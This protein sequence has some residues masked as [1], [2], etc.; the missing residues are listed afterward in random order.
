M[1]PKRS[2]IIDPDTNKLVRIGICLNCRKT[3]L[4]MRS[5]H[6][7]KKFCSEQCRRQYYRKEKRK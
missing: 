3:F 6:N 1:K 4:I 2:Y 5:Y 7:N